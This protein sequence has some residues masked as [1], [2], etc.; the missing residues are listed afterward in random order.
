M[1]EIDYFKIS[2]STK[3]Q[4]NLVMECATFIEHLVSIYL[5]HL[6]DIDLENSLA[7]G[8][9]AQ[10]IDL[11]QKVK[12]LLD[13]RAF[14]DESSKKKFTHF[15]SIRNKFAHVHECINFTTCFSFLDGDNKSLEKMY[16]SKITIA[17]VEKRNE[18]LFVELFIDVRKILDNTIVKIKE[19]A[20][21]KGSAIGTKISLEILNASFKEYAELHPEFS[22]HIGEIYDLANAKLEKERENI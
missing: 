4:R 2:A 13:L 8:N 3:T 16:G 22:T 11:N 18:M 15:V 19:K 6:I 14:N 7:F 12:I 5:C 21:E 10:G 17:D 20:Q 1:N 9:K